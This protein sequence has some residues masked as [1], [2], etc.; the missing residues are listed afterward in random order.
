MLLG[1]CK[2]MQRC[3]DCVDKESVINT[4]SVSVPRGVKIVL[5]E[6]V[7]HCE[8]MSVLSGSVGLSLVVN[9]LLHRISAS[10]LSTVS[11]RF[12]GAAGNGS[13]SKSM[14]LLSGALLWLGSKSS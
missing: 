13:V 12:R 14:H 8:A 10:T 3:S 1:D 9:S 11:L 7:L 6:L 2:I 4:E 5:L